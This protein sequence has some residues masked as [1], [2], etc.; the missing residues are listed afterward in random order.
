MKDFAPVGTFLASSFVAGCI[1]IST[2]ENSKGGLK[3]AVEKSKAEA[4]EKSKAEVA[5]ISALHE[6]ERQALLE[7]LKDMEKVSAAQKA[8]MESK[9]QAQE[10]VNK[11]RLMR[12]G[13]LGY[14][15]GW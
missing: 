8:E 3:S 14:I 6:V 1:V 13:L 12:R 7:K 2:I 5:K 4:V 15:F 11:E 10:E 9:F